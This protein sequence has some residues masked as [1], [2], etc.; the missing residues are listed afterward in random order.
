MSNPSAKMFKRAYTAALSKAMAECAAITT[1]LDTGLEALAVA[2]FGS[3]DRVK[4]GL[5]APPETPV[6]IHCWHC[7]GKY[8]S[9]KM[10]LGYRPRCQSAM[11][12]SIGEGIASI[13]PLWW[14][15]NADCDGAGFGHDLHEIKQRKMKP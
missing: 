2:T 11:V 15:K 4:E 1:E 12:E 5:F 8:Q 9:D 3:T 7:G 6:K 13:A 10:R 14:C